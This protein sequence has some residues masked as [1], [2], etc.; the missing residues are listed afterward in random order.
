MPT[1]REVQQTVAQ[2]L[3]ARDDSA[4]ANHIVDDQIPAVDRLRIYRNT[5]IGT[6]I[7]A[8][9]LTFPVV[10]RL[11]AQEFFEGSAA[12]FVE[13]HPPRSAYLN[14][15]GAAFGDFLA[16]FPP[17]SSLPYLPDVVRLEWAVSCAAC[18]PDAP[19]LDP[20]ALATFDEA[21]QGKLR[22]VAHPS[23]RLIAVRYPADHVWRAVR[24]TD[25]EALANI[26]LKLEPLWLLVHRCDGGVVVRRLTEEEG[27]FTAALCAGRPLAEAIPPETPANLVT[28]LA[29]HLA[30]G[31]F[32]G[33]EAAPSEVP[34]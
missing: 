18:A 28:M 34:L 17:A 15:Y 2:S 30:K 26:D 29:E 27:R 12:A 16:A 14:E 24:D 5:F 11:V 1:L 7:S 25:D 3:L 20:V 22:F 31:R 4:A 9:R 23:V 10:E 19:V 13:R 6:L 21:D 8:L 32:A 33:I